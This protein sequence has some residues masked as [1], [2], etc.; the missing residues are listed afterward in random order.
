MKT[1]HFCCKFRFN[2]IEKDSLIGSDREVIGREGLAKLHTKLDA[3]I[4]ADE[5]IATLY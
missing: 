4:E 2:L 5:V 1:K 3:V